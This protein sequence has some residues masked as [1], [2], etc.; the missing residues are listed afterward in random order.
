MSDAA[1]TA[2]V[3]G[4]VNIV[5]MVIGFL[6]LWMKVKYGAEKAAA[7]VTKAE[8]AEETLG[9]KI[10]DNTKITQAGADAVARKLNGG[11]DQALA[12]ATAP[13]NERLAQNE[14]KIAELAD[15]HHKA[16]HDLANALDKLSLKVEL[17][18]QQGRAQKPPVAATG[19]GNGGGGAS[20][21]ER[22]ADPGAVR[23]STEAS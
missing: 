1:V 4:A 2:V 13:I 11:L 19:T 5:G 16:K 6:T 20:A 12:E 22:R 8:A 14:Q 18:V 10:D 17:L 9:R 15:Y 7:A 3:A 23:P 21:G